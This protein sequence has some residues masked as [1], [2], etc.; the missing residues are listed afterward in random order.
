MISSEQ[1]A[2]GLSCGLGGLDH[3]ARIEDFDEGSRRVGRGLVALVL[4]ALACDS[5]QV[6]QEFLR[7]RVVVP[8]DELLQRELVPRGD[9]GGRLVR[10]EVGVEEFVLGFDGD[11]AGRGSRAWGVG[12]R[13]G[14]RLDRKSVV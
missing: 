7:V 2:C 10:G 11:G 4:G 6:F 12:S 14:G 5:I 3:V 1:L 8:G 9:R 13:W